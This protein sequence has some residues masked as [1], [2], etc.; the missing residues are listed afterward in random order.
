[1]T[2]GD[3]SQ[4]MVEQARRNLAESGHPFAFGRFD[5]QAIP[6]SEG[7]F[8]AVIANHMLY[9]VPD[10]QRTYAEVQ[11]V[12]KPGGHFYA[13]ANS[14]DTMG[15]IR[16]LEARVGIAGGAQ[17]FH[18]SSAFFLESGAAV[19]APWFSRIALHR[20]EEAPLVTE[21]QPLIE[22]IS[23]PSRTGGTFRPPHWRDCGRRSRQRYGNR[24][25]S[26]STKSPECWSR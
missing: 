21:A 2:L 10:R 16:E 25:R 4:G 22:Y 11:R 17:G 20:Q 18:S 12:L 24:E 14:R 13:A 5:A 15:Q 7:S 3:V 19:L 6:F 8:D 1:M 23:C 26:A 9:H